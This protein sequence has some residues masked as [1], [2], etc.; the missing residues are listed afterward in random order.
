MSDFYE[1]YG[2]VDDAATIWVMKGGGSTPIKEMSDSHIENASAMLKRMV[3]SHQLGSL[4]SLAAACSFDYAMRAAD[5]DCDRAEAFMLGVEIIERGF[6]A[7][8]K[9]REKLRC[10]TG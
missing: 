7:E 8:R 2:V 3:R 9:R 10:T 4:Q 1:K 6:E 5:E